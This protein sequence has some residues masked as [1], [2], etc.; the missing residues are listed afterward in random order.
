M[1]HV[2]DSYLI[3]ND[4]PFEI[5][6]AL[7]FPAIKYNRLNTFVQV[8]HGKNGFSAIFKDKGQLAYLIIWHNGLGGKV[9][10]IIAFH[11]YNVSRSQWFVKEKDE[12]NNNPLW[13]GV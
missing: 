9:K 2:L 10:N 8:Q 13:A 1:Y 6:K 7:L 3:T 4:F 5:L 11:T 12:K